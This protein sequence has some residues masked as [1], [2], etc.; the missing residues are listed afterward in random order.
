LEGKRVASYNIKTKQSY[1]IENLTTALPIMWDQSGSYLRIQEILPNIK[2]LPESNFSSEVYRSVNVYIST[3]GEEFDRQA[4]SEKTEL[5]ITNPLLLLAEPSHVTSKKKVVIG[6]TMIEF[7]NGDTQNKVFNFSDYA[8]IEIVEDAFVRI[9]NPGL[10]IDSKTDLGSYTLGTVLPTGV[11][12]IDADKGA[13]RFINSLAVI[14]DIP[15]PESI[16]ASKLGTE[17][18]KLEE[19]AYQDVD[20]ALSCLSTNNAPS[21]K[22][23]LIVVNDQREYEQLLQFLSSHRNCGNFVLPTINFSQYT[24]LGKLVRGNGC[25]PALIRHMYKDNVHKK[26]VFSIYIDTHERPESMCQAYVESMNWSLLP[27]I[28]SDYAVELSLK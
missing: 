22:S 28:P 10:G 7:I 15:L 16:S 4:V 18:N 5:S 12:F 9:V 8:K 25:G 26:I 14:K 21:F 27:K 1:S 17:T 24:L 13:V 6:N 23:Q 11:I 2:Y 19:I 20:E 3:K